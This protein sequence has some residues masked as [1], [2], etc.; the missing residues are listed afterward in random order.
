M[1]CPS[2]PDSAEQRSWTQRVRPD[3]DWR[4]FVDEEVAAGKT[5]AEAQLGGLVRL[6]RVMPGG[7]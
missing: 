3:G 6:A 7:D 4:A 5:R 1:M 2:T